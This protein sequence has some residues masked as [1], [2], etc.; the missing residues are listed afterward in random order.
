MPVGSEYQ[1]VN[2]HD[3]TESIS[4]GLGTVG[5]HDEQSSGVALGARIYG[6]NTA[7]KLS[8]QGGVLIGSD[9]YPNATSSNHS[10][11]GS[12]VI[13]C[14]SG[15]LGGGVRN[16]IVGSD[17]ASQ[18]SGQTDNVVLGYSAANRS[19]IGFNTVLIGASAGRSHRLN[20]SDHTLST[21]S[22]II[23]KDCARS[24]ATSG[25][26]TIGSNATL[27]NCGSFSTSDSDPGADCICIGRGTLSELVGSTTG[28]IVIGNGAVHN[29]CLISTDQSITLKTDSLSNISTTGTSTTIR[30]LGTADSHSISLLCGSAS[31]VVF[32]RIAFRLEGVPIT[33]DGVATDLSGKSI[34]NVGSSYWVSGA[35]NVTPSTEKRR[36]VVL[37]NQAMASDDSATRSM[38]AYDDGEGDD[39]LLPSERSATAARLLAGA[40]VATGSEMYVFFQRPPIGWKCI[41]ARLELLS[42]SSNAASSKQI[43][44]FSRSYLTAIDSDPTNSDYLTIHVNQSLDK[45]TCTDVAF[46]TAWTPGPTDYLVGHISDGSSNNTFMGGYLEIE[47][48]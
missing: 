2:T 26:R 27:L 40:R 8:L 38:N 5:S 6:S 44:I 28:E 48:I 19:V 4:I 41:G 23:G 35:S 33:H 9:I 1:N 43:E 34:R 17:A 10:V 7:E 42:K 22:V 30:N 31:R 12:V 39:S 37:P 24:L 36:L 14:E 15:G 13:G 21:G 25:A 29:T 20:N 46:T 16:V 32:S 47:R 11:E 3:I 18:L 45:R